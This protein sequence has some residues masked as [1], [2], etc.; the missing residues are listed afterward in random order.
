MEDPRWLKYELR[1]SAAR[2]QYYCRSAMDCGATSFVWLSS[3][4]GH[5]CGLGLVLWGVR[6]PAD[7]AS[8]KFGEA[9]LSVTT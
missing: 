4:S 5:Q 1:A 2:R 7:P 9:T 3:G 8:S 6:H